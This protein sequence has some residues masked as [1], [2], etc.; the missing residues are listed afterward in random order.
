MDDALRFLGVDE[1]VDRCEDTF[2]GGKCLVDLFFPAVVDAA[3]VEMLSFLI[4]L[5]YDMLLSLNVSSIS[6]AD[7]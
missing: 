5:R 6:K 7:F 2:K 3:V 4:E 1:A